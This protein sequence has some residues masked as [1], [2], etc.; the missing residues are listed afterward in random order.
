[1]GEHLKVYLN[2]EKKKRKY[3]SQ[4]HPCLGA[5]MVDVSMCEFTLARKSR[6][7][8]LFKSPPTRIQTHPSLR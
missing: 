2:L 8:D 5:Y 3:Y 1:M 4:D 6:T 7:G